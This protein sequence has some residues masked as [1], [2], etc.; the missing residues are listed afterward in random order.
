VPETPVLPP[1]LAPRFLTRAEAARYLGVGPDTFADEV[2]A[3]IWPQGWPRGGKGGKLT[4]DRLLLDRVADGR[5]G[6]Q[7][8]PPASQAGEDDAVAAVERR[9]NGQAQGQR[10]QRRHQAAA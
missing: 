5:S 2:A 6:L 3:G 4:W 1:G 7:Q 9:I 10:D 8:P